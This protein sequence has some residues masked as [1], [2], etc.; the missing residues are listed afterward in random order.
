MPHQSADWFAMTGYR[1]VRHMSAAG[2]GHPALRVRDLGC[3][4][5]KTPVGRGQ[6][7]P[8][9][10]VQYVSSGGTHECRPT[11]KFAKLA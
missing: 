3:G 6:C 11:K 8:P 10:G 9:L 2:W 4:V 7:A 1:E 5:G